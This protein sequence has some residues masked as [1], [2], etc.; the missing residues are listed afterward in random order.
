MSE[1]RP[2]GRLEPVSLRDYWKKED[3]EFT[4][5]L[6]I[7]ENLNC[8]AE[9]VGM[10]LELV[11]TET[12][13]GPFRADILCRDG[14][15]AAYV[16]F[17]NQLEQTD[18]LHLGQLMTYAAGLDAVRIIWIAQK[19]NEEHRAALD[20]LN[21]ITDEGF[22]FFGIEIEL[23]KIG[24]SPPAPRFNIVSKPNDWSK[25]AKVQKQADLTERAA[26]YREIWTSIFNYLAD[27]FPAIEIPSATG[28]H[29]IRLPMPNT[30]CVLSY[31][32]TQKKLS[33]YLLFREDSPS[34]WFNFIYS[35]KELLETELG[36]A[37]EWESKDDGTGFAMTA[38]DFDH[39][40]QKEQE[41]VYTKIGDLLTKISDQFTKKTREFNEKR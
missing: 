20:W 1:K 8:L 6:A 40:S 14:D 9:A 12:K 32:P 30:R 18:H 41:G 31:A 5:W 38:F 23:W 21:R 34:G 24:D 10:R 15:S 36:Q 7:P 39:L 13:V 16:L 33:M 35:G 22:E 29:W 19:F 17:E 2:L 27:N 28:L 37:F 25:A 26:M 3:T 11:E 4:P